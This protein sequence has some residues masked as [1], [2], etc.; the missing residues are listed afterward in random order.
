MI[1]PSQFLREGK[2]K[3]WRMERGKFDKSGGNYKIKK[4]KDKRYEESLKEK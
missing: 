1:A 2:R 3:K 4:G